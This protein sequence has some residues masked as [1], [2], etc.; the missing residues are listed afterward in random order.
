MNTLE[1]FE[2]CS[3]QKVHEGKV[4]D[5]IRLD[6]DKRL[7]IVTDRISA[8]NKKL[9]NSAVPSKG[10]VLNTLS[11]FWFEKTKHIIGNHLVKQI[12]DNI[13]IVKEARPVRIEMIV[14]AFLTGS[15]WRAYSK[16]KRIFNGQK[17]KDGMSFNQAFE[18]PI[19]TPTT[20]DEYDTEITEE[21]I[22]KSGLA[23]KD[24][25][26]RMKEA[27]SELF[28]FASEFLSERGIILVDTKYE[29]G[30]CDNKLILI[31]E[32][33]TPDSS[34]FWRKSEY[35]KSPENVEQIDKEFVRRR[36]SEDKKNGIL[37]ES[38]PPDVISETSKRYKEI[39]KII[40][41]EQYKSPSMNLK[42]RIY[43]ALLRNKLIKPAHLIIAVGS[44]ADLQYANKIQAQARHFNISTELK[45]F[46]ENFNLTQSIKNAQKYNHCTEPAAL[47]C[48]SANSETPADILASNLNIPVIKC[49]LKKEI[50]R[51][52]S[53]LLHVFDTENAL[54]AAVRALNIPEMREKINRNIC[55]KKEFFNKISI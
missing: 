50:N 30:F 42:A 31:D 24:S 15:V 40:T 45:I 48:I 10:A 2:S 43:H 28:N 54:E 34:R 32:I 29:F 39:Y 22:L 41:G 25:Y 38:L 1:R 44:E 55:A 47:I 3:L 12:D 37:P 21:Q 7:I 14:R 20:K 23:D 27:A 36:I 13:S 49:H 19:I 53:P 11:N 9:K 51:S 46:P 6:K 17:L 4:R 18:K 35:E 52:N 16:G 8:F 5:G 26:R 33:H